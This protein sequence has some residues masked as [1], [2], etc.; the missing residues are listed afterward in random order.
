M[1]S[2]ACRRAEPRQKEPEN[3]GPEEPGIWRLEV[4][5]VGTV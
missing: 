4:V 2:A 3:E 5:E 1:E